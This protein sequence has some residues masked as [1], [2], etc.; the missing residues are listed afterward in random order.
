MFHC[1]Q[2]LFSLKKVEQHRYRTENKV[3][4]YSPPLKKSSLS[5]KLNHNK[6][7]KTPLACTLLLNIFTERFQSLFMRSTSCPDHRRFG[8]S[9]FNIVQVKEWHCLHNEIKADKLSVW[10]ELINSKALQAPSTP[11]HC[12]T[13][14][15]HKFL[16]TML[17]KERNGSTPTHT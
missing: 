10:R 15:F 9:Q 11:H 7:S 13:L 16:R 4:A 5:V 12:N 8:K 14:L 2:K 3:K 6:W 1:H 17:H